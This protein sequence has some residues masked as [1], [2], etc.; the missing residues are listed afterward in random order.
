MRAVKLSLIEALALHPGS[1]VL[2]VGCGTGDD[3]RDLALF[4]GPAG[5]VTGV[6]KSAFLVGEARRRNQRVELQPEFRCA[7]AA[8]LPFP[9]SSFE[10][11]RAERVLMH[12][13]D[14]QQV[15]YEMARVTRPGG[16][17]AVF[18]FDW[19]LLLLAHPDE[20]ATRGMT[21]QFA[22]ALKHGRIALRLP[23][24]FR[25]AG[26]TDIRATPIGL[27]ADWELFA[28]ISRNLRPDGSDGWWRQLEQLVEAG[29]F[30]CVFHGL[31]VSGLR[32]PGAPPN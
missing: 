11:V 25:R 10:A 27:Q 32:D 24:L 12:V 15:V 23:A 7:D 18:D 20:E 26:L 29:E 28:F 17:V 3:A 16:R 31:V 6:D 21:R 9:D 8:E 14:P 22:Q 2:D 13:D 5:T 19:E 1:A 4:V 30:L